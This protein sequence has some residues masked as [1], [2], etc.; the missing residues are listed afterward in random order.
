[1]YGVAFGRAVRHED[2][3]GNLGSRCRG[4]LF[5]AGVPRR[6][7]DGACHGGAYR[8]D[9]VRLNRRHYEVQ[10]RIRRKLIMANHA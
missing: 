3:R 9:D 1:M 7:Y 4:R 6:G 2:E 10:G 5:P 8:Q